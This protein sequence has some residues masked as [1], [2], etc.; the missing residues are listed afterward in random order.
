[1]R[2][3]AELADIDVRAEMS[4]PCPERRTG[5][6]AECRRP[7]AAERREIGTL[8]RRRRLLSCQALQQLGGCGAAYKMLYHAHALRWN[9]ALYSLH[10]EIL[11]VLSFFAGLADL[12]KPW[13]IA[14]IVSGGVYT[15]FEFQKPPYNP[16]E[17]FSPRVSW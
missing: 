5:P 1:M 3:S 16:I 13:V 2:T 12:I 8:R 11:S 10:S 17:M 14:L 15:C 4:I 7:R 6:P 9:L